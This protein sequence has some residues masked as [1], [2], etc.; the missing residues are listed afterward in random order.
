M[1]LRPGPLLIL[2]LAGISLITSAQVTT[3]SSSAESTLPV[4]VR[5]ILDI[6]K[7]LG[8][9]SFDRVKSDENSW[10]TQQGI[11]FLGANELALYQVNRT[12][13]STVNYSL[14]VEILDTKDG[15]EL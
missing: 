4:R 12:E 11:A 13:T 2:L 8:Y 1:R 14:Q 3:S 9:E 7:K 5:W 15:H 10:K 6:K